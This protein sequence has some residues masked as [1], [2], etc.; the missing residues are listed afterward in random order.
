MTSLR[1]STRV[2]ARQHHGRITDRGNIDKLPVSTTGRQSIKLREKALSHSVE[3]SRIPA[4][5]DDDNVPSTGDDQLAEKKWK[6]WSTYATSSPFPDFHHPTRRECEEAYHVLHEMHNDAVETEFQDPNTP[7]TIPHVLDAMIV[8]VLSQATNWKN[9]KRAMDSLAQTYGSIFAYDEILSG[10]I[11]R[12]QNTLRC[13]GLHMRKSMIIMS[14]LEEVQH[15]HN[16]W[17]L[18]HL[19]K[20]SDEEAMK[21]LMSYKYMGSKS[22]FVVMGWCLKRNNF[23]VDTHVYRIAGLWGWR[24]EKASR[25]MTQSHLDALVPAA[26]EWK[27]DI[28]WELHD[29]WPDFTEA[30]MRSKGRCAFCRAFHQIIS[31]CT[32]T[33]NIGKLLNAP[34]QRGTKF[35]ASL[36]YVVNCEDGGQNVLRA[37]EIKADFDTG[38]CIK[39]YWPITAASKD[40]Q[41]SSLSLA[42]PLNHLN[43]EYLSWMNSKIN[44]CID[45]GHLPSQDGFVPERLIK[46]AGDTLHLVLTTDKADLDFHRPSDAVV[47]TQAL[48]IPYLWVDALC[49]LQDQASD[50]EYQCTQMEK[51][52]G[53]AHVTIC[54]LVNNCEEGFVERK[55]KITIPYQFQDISK[56]PAA[57]SIYEPSYHR[58]SLDDIMRSEWIVRGWTFQER[59]ASTRILSFGASNVHF[60]CSRGQYAT[61]EYQISYDFEMVR[62]DLLNSSGPHELYLQ[63]NNEVAEEF[64]VYR[65]EFTRP[66]DVL[67]S[68]A[69]LAVLFAS[70]LHDRYLAGLWEN[71]LYRSLNWIL[72]PEGKSSYSRM[73]DRL[74]RP[75]PY[76]APSWSWASRNSLISF[77]IW[78]ETMDASAARLECAILDTVVNPVGTGLFGELLGGHIDISGNVFNGS[79]RLS[80]VEADNYPFRHRDTL[81]LDDQYLLDLDTDCNVEDLFVKSGEKYELDAPV[82]LLV[83]GSTIGKH[84]FWTNRSRSQDESEPED[85]QGRIA[86]GL[87]I[88]PAEKPG[89]FY[90][91]GTFISRRQGQG[92]LEF[93]ETCERKNVRLV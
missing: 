87:L 34:P 4:A 26:T 25:E 88:H 23:T 93:F 11:Q 92:G 75:V 86:Y 6:S 48:S 19:F 76:I 55:D 3:H 57:F 39:I 30:S 15:R 67:P 54:A 58:T 9:A 33:H 53:N 47:A 13:G 28:D 74:T 35:R 20:L 73:L 37:L 84:T 80:F 42:E 56:P 40:R 41:I 16:K 2:L 38:E 62:R 69:G 50:W 17:D 12:L 65:F 64:T 71:D 81:Q 5:S 85:E 46:V 72:R 77:N 82:D 44:S 1:R 24:P 18:D 89:E 49:I 52:Y 8:A 91:I 27:V 63:W 45:H 14:I 70:K 43:P 29:V 78:G 90:R 79:R 32:G 68:L 7:E 22:A 31:G 10:G 59:G 21:E 36:Y 60:Q 61:S 51:I 83:I 66:S